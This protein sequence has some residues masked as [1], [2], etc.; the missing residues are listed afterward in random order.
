MAL[1]SAQRVRLKHVLAVWMRELNPADPFDALLEKAIDALETPVA[2][3]NAVKNRI[4]VHRDAIAAHQAS[5]PAIR[6]VEDTTV[7]TDLT[8]LDATKAAL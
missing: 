8:D 1:T 4:Q 2:A 3:K 5:L 6:T 7:A